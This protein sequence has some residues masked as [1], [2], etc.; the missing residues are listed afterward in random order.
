MPLAPLLA[1]VA[2]V[3][4]LA[5]PAPY[6]FSVGERLTY[7][8]K[9]GYFP[10]GTATVS[11]SRMAQERGLEAF[12]FAATG[13]GG[14]PGVRM[15]YEMTS[16]VGTG[17]FSSLRFHRKQ[18]QG[19]TVT[20]E[21]YQIVPD[22]SRYRIEGGTQDW[23]APK[24]AL[25]ELAF[26][27]YLRT[28]PLEV[29]KS[30]T[31]SRYFRTGYNPIGVRVIGRRTVMLPDGRSVPALAVEVTSRGTTMGVRFTDDARR[32]P[33]EVDLPLPFGSVTLELTGGS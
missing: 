17:R 32:L 20:E 18:I 15:R 30:F 21:R 5:T 12:V 3:A 8:A 19:T 2:L 24:D 10:I 25:D 27:Y 33:A 16:W 23:A 1:H 4:T 29:G 11:V 9:L 13:E 6:P 26:L 14:P 28:V 22:S 31:V 7:D